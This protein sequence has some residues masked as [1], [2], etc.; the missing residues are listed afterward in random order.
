MPVTPQYR[1]FQV[2]NAPIEGGMLSA[3]VSADSFGAV[4][5]RQGMEVAQGLGQAGSAISR[6]GSQMA[7]DNERLDNALVRDASVQARTKMNDI[8]ARDILTKTGSE[9]LDLESTAKQRFSEA[10]KEIEKT[11]RTPQQKSHFA[12]EFDSFQSQNLLSVF[13]HQEGQRKEYDKTTKLAENS[14]SVN[15]AV[16]NRLDPKRVEQAEFD[17][18]QNTLSLHSTEHPEVKKAQVAS[19]LNNL[20][21]GMVEAEGKASARSGLAMLEKYKEK[22]NPTEY[23]K[24]KNSL[25]NKAVIESAQ[26]K[27]ILAYGQSMSDTQALDYANKEIKDPRERDLFLKEVQT[28]NAIKLKGETEATRSKVQEIWMKVYDNPTAEIPKDIPHE[29]YGALKD[30]QRERVT[31]A[32]KP[33]P[34]DPEVVQRLNTVPLADFEKENLFEYRDQLSQHD[35]NHFIELQKKLKDSGNKV[36]KDKMRG[37]SAQANEYLSG[38]PDFD[39]KEKDTIEVRNQKATRHSL[40]M[41]EFNRQLSQIPEDK[42]TQEKAQEIM[43]SLTRQNTVGKN[44]LGFG[45]EK[46]YEFEKSKNPQIGTDKPD[47]I[48]NVPESNVVFDQKTGLYGTREGA[49][50]KFRDAEGKAKFQAPIKTAPTSTKAPSNHTSWNFVPQGFEPVDDP[51]RLEKGLSDNLKPYARDFVEAGKQYGVD[52]GTLAAIAMHETGRGTSKAFQEGQN[53]M[54]VSDA[55]GWVSFAARG[56]VRGSIYKMSKTISQSDFYKDAR[57]DQSLASIGKNYAPAG[58]GN[59]PNNL[60]RFWVDGVSKFRKELEDA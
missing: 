51:I 26:E 32:S 39:I 40:F 35:L 53:A 5:A 30:Y 21:A 28:Q 37:F 48:K 15:E 42:I 14:L 1:P 47:W 22:I 4:Q 12:Q 6:I 45:G 36:D 24:Q 58:A 55:K 59:D 25:E 3:N 11:L 18:T 34:S 31:Q 17:I 16:M 49:V 46:V 44:W 38:H 2:K 27:A 7:A 33:R 57:S 23:E 10:R 60:N 9:A 8:M 41:D 19:A 43:S 50:I 52:P 13:R 20:Y 29:V 56:G 54:G